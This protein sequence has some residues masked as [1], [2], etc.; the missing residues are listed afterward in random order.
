MLGFGVILTLIGLLFPQQAGEVIE[1][2][3]VKT[4]EAF[5]PPRP[6]VDT[7]ARTIWG[8]A[9]GEGRE[10]MVAVANVVMNRYRLRQSGAGYRSFGPVGASVAQICTA[11]RQFSA[12][13]HGDPNRAAMLNVTEQSASFA[14]AMEIARAAVAGSLSDITGGADHYH[15]RTVNPDWAE[16]V[17][18][19]KAI[20][21]HVFYNITN[22]GFV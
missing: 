11:P 17:A 7:L 2:A 3:I 6:D 5:G 10:G 22:R 21:K 1:S 16:G 19:V 18:P 20:G 12:W 8:E 9:R 4:G 15:A 13:N 14:T